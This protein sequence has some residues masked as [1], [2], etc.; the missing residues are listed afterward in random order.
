MD[1]PQTGAE[2]RTVVVSG[3]RMVVR[4][5]RRRRRMEMEGDGAGGGVLCTVHL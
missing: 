3:Q 5:I 1:G 4:V 2:R